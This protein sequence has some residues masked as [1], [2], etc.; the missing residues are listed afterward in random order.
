MTT[1]RWMRRRMG[2]TMG[3]S[4]RK[5]DGWMGGCTGYRTRFSHHPVFPKLVGNGVRSTERAIDIDCDTMRC[6]VELVLPYQGKF[7]R[8]FL[9]SSL[10]SEHIASHHI[11]CLA[12][13]FYPQTLTKR[14]PSE[15][16][17]ALCSIAVLLF[18]PASSAADVKYRPM[19]ASFEL[20]SI[21][22]LKSSTPQNI[23]RIIRARALARSPGA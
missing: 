5:T 22:S 21:A 3:M 17:V 7:V 10:R 15:L 1:R 19:Y 13:I 8:E 6:N 16:T 9:M 20:L 4:P 12:I 23:Q 14:T 18:R 11:A 2:R